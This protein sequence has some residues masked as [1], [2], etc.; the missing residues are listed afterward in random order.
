MT[1]GGLMIAARKRLGEEK[2]QAYYLRGK[3]STR[4]HILAWKLKSRLRKNETRAAGQQATIYI[5]GHQLLDTD[6]MYKWDVAQAH[7]Q[8]LAEFKEQLLA[9]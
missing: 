3:F 7:C 9:E 4:A 5:E 2:Y 8:N 1:T 6:L